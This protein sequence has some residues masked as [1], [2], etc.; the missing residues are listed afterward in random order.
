MRGALALARG[1]VYGF[2]FLAVGSRRKDA[3]LF[4]QIA[5]RASISRSKA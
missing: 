1:F 2:W 5:G 3:R 4:T